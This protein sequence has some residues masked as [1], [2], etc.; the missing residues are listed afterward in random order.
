M[1]YTIRDNDG[2]AVATTFGCLR[3]HS[4]FHFSYICVT[5]AAIS[6]VAMFPQLGD[7][8]SKTK[9]PCMLQNQYKTNVAKYARKKSESSQKSN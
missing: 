8:T 5:G 7:K 1:L 3:V 9:L 4:G 6:L 2:S